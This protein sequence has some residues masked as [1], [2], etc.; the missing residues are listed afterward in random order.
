M[1]TTVNFSQFCDAFRDFGRNE[2]FSYNGKRALYDW[3]E[4]LSEETGQEQEL[5][6]IALCCEFNEYA[7]LE[8]FHAD[9]DKENYPDLET[10]REHTQVIEIPNSEG[11]I[12][13]MF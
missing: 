11:F 2:N 10:L 13:Q 6:I 8:E 5:D 4:E 7:D 3:L 12:I 9:Y 1:K